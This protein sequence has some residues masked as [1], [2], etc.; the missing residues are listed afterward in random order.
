MHNTQQDALPESHPV[1][2]SA[3]RSTDIPAFYP[4]WFVNRWKAGYAMWINPFNQA[5][6]KVC[7]D[8]AKAV[9]FW[10]KNPAPLIPHLDELEALGLKTY[11]FQFTLNDYEKENF[12]PNVPPLYERIETFKKLSERIG[13]DRVIWRFDPLIMYDGMDPEVLVKRIFRIS[14]E[15][16][17][18]TD[19]LVFSFA[20]VQSYRKVQNNLCR[21][22]AYAKE[23]SDSEGNVPQALFT[24]ENVLD[25]EISTENRL[26]IAQ[27]L[28][29]MRD[30]WSQ[31]GWNLLLATCAENIDLKSFSIEHNSCIDGELLLKLANK[32]KN[33][34]LAEFLQKK[35]RSKKKKGTA[36]QQSLLPSYLSNANMK[37][38]GQRP[39][40]GCVESKDIGMY[41]TCR[42]FC[43]YCY[44]NVSKD[45]VFKN[46]FRHRDDSES[47][48]D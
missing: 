39:D 37:D 20:D 3:S 23:G 27:R 16:Q 22:D 4:Q 18:Y 24:K 43:V 40:C 29:D 28:A 6:M 45:A 10:T 32:D 12:E 42:H 14:E 11:Y 33:V 34:P 17:G 21:N 9:V 15:L 35:L 19:K 5:R 30:Y 31:N 7:F 47:L 41:S 13:R 25:A 38:K 46:K 2:V 36:L 26:H 48:I 8:K 1:I 44:A